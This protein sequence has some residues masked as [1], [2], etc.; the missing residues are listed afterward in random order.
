MD[1]KYIEQ[2][3]ERYF[4]CET[5][6]QEEQILKAFFAQQE[7]EVPSQ[8]RQYIPLFQALDDSRTQLGDDFD[9]RILEL[10]CEPRIV[11]ARTIGIGERLRPLLRAAAIIG[12]V[13]T[14]G[15]AVN[16]S[17]KSEQTATDE[18]NYSAYKDT[19][20]DP[21]MAYDKVEDALQLLSEGFI[22]VRM[23]DSIRIDSLYS[24]VK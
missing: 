12:V 16:L 10:T 11:K 3:V 7:Q 18:I 13:F 17:M 14:I 5:S 24:E 15:T 2:L 4:Q 21:T 8:L 9:E 1:Y 19:Y 22:Q 23:A 6:L 20:E